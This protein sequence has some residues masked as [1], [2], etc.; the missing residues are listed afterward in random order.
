MK[1]RGSIMDKSVDDDTVTNLPFG[2]T[3]G[4]AAGGVPAYS[5][6]YDQVDPQQYPNRHAFRNYVDGVYTGYKWQCVEFARRWLLINCGYVFDDVAMAYDIFRLPHVT[7]VA[8]DEKLPL[9]AFRN[10][11]RRRPKPGALLIW[12][13][14]GMF[15][16][17]G[18]VAVITAVTDTYVRVAEQ[19]V[20]HH[21]WNE[22]ADWSRELA[23][24]VGEDGSYWIRCSYHDGEILGWV[25][26]TDNSTEA[27]VFPAERPELM[28][29]RGRQASRHGQHQ[30]TWL[31]LANPEEEAF[32]QAMGGHRL[33]TRDADL[34]R[35]FAIS[36]TAEAEL[37]RATNEL[38]A[39][40]LHATDHV[41]QDDR[42][43]E[44]F[45]IPPVLWPRIHQ[46]WDNRRTQM[47]TGRFDFCV[48]EDGLKVYEY[49]CDSAS[50]HLEAGRVQGA[51]AQHFGVGEGH[52][53]GEHLWERLVAAWKD[54][55]ARGTVHLMIDDDPEELYH[56]LNMKTAI[57]AA[58]LSARVIRGLDGL[59]WGDDGAVLDPEGA[60][61]RWVWKSW[62]WETALDQLRAEAD[63][64][65]QHHP[66]PRLMDV[67]FQ[68]DTMVFE[69]LWTLI[70]SNKA[71]LPVLWEMFPD[72]RYLL[73]TGHK[74]TDRLRRRGYVSKP[75]AGRCGENIVIVPG[76]GGSD[77]LASATEGRFDDQDLV[78][79][80][81]APLPKVGAQFVQ[82]CTFTTGGVYAGSCV[83]ADR[84]PIIAAQS[85]VL[86]LRVLDDDAFA[87]KG[88]VKKPGGET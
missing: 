57:E 6:D 75:I 79:Q 27:A 42:R 76:A 47:I 62:A 15:E 70:P 51:W 80:E 33:A 85:D 13:E 31:N 10:G 25:M 3:I 88:G 22:G 72:R 1:G 43:L 44:R 40:F 29:I 19:N 21:P 87:R 12:K 50:C 18:H 58:G 69:P 52:D 30:R 74:L 17:T 8:T 5:S 71:I 54:S 4:I 20:T 14:G 61:I 46:S 83:R 86:P 67:L 11:A 66:R 73:E 63:E 34:Y 64:E 2:A 26:Q 35:W 37:R 45:N 82:I 55:E 60:P 59:R 36:T 7:V 16:L 78:W 28:Q 39:M 65:A 9:R 68:P 48:T 84:S 81:L 49:N 32:V 53:P 38:H 41:L 77:N 24:H 56:G 23:A